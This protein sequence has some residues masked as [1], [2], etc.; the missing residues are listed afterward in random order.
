MTKVIALASLRAAHSVQA[1]AL[2]PTFTPAPARL[3]RVP[4]ATTVHRKQA[5]ESALTLAL[6]YVRCG[7]N[8]SNLHAATAKALRASTMLKQAC[9][10]A[11]TSG[12][13]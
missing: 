11:T 12:R 13:A 9:A 2:S 7:G 3:V 8:P 4:G 6:H 1:P 10:E 5:I